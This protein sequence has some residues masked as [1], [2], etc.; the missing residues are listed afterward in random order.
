MGQDF[1]EIGFTPPFCPY[2]G[3]YDVSCIRCMLRTI[4]F[5]KDNDMEV[6]LQ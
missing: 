3:S 4:S 1:P 5:G 6:L 2:M